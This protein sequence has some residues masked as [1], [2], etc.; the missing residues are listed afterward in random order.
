LPIFTLID[1]T[2]IIMYIYS[3]K[4]QLNMNIGQN[5]KR[6]RTAKNMSQKELTSIIDMGAA[7]FSRI[8]NGKTDPS[9][10]TLERIAKALGV[11]LSELFIDENSDTEVIS[12]DKTIM[13]KVRLI[14]SLQED[15]KQVIFKMLD[16]FVSKQTLKS[17]LQNAINL[18]S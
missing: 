8:E 11:S 7:Q 9:V 3:Y 15:E 12:H 17:A 1:K 16:A 5:I 18:A 2:G 4:K 13:E 14:E 10:N 6:V